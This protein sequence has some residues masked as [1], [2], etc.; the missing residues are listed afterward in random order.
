MDWD[1][2]TH[3]TQY[4]THD[5]HTYPAKMVPQVAKKA[6][7][8]YGKNARLIFDPFCGTGTTL[9]EAKLK[10]IHSIGSDLNPLARLIASVKSTNIEENTLKLYLKEFHK[11]YFDIIFG[12]QKPSPEIIPHFA[13]IDYWF[14][15]KVIRDLALIK[16]FINT[17]IDNIL[18][19]NFFLVCF[20]Q[21]VR[22]CSWQRNDEF[23]LYKMPVEKI[24]YFNLEVFPEME[25]IM[26]NNYFSL[27]EC[28]KVADNE[29][30]PLIR[31]FNS[32]DYIPKRI[33][34]LESVDMVL[35][36]PPYGD[37]STTVAYGQFSALPSQWVYDNVNGR[38]LDKELMGGLKA[39]QLRKYKSDILGDHVNEISKVDKSR[40]LEVIAFYRD[41]YKSI[42]NISRTVKQNGFVCYVVSNRTVRGINLRT[43]LITID[44]F[45]AFGFNHIETHDRKISHKRLPRKNSSNGKKGNAADLMNKEHIIVMQR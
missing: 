41:Y 11:Y 8:E 13:N 34:P 37:S 27:L 17:H 36:S 31:D 39:K 4:L 21:T 3:D 24:R 32:V 40:A 6:I 15:K 2:D 1:F 28:S 12:G 43:D 38:K 22:N 20:S 45:K 26:A 18:V 29:Y 44:F 25:R 42:A 35:T 10:K 7:D 14:S 33:V 30:S 9:L 5:I 19:K 16:Q 23:K